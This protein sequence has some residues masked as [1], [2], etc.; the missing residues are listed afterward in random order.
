MKTLIRLASVVAIFFLVGNFNV[1]AQSRTKMGQINKAV[2]LAST[3]ER[4]T[5]TN[6]WVTSAT[7]VGITEFRSN[8]TS[9]NWVGTSSVNGTQWLPIEPGIAGAVTITAPPN[10]SFNLYDLYIDVG[11]DTDEITIHYFN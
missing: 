1:N 9:T 4:A 2:A 5:S 8:S 11:A 7:F 3:P 10:S 6:L